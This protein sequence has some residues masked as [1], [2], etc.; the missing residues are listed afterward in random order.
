MLKTIECTL[1]NVEDN[2]WDKVEEVQ[3]YKGNDHDDKVENVPRQFEVVPTKGDYLYEGL[4]CEY[5]YEDEIEVLE[6][7]RFCA[8]LTVSLNGHACHVEY[9]DDHDSDVKHLI[10]DDFEEEQLELKLKI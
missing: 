5:G 3:T 9:Y 8:R 10:V 1:Y 6:C 7:V 4:H 2:E